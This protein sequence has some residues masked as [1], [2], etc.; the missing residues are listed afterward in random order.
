MNSNNKLEAVNKKLAELSDYIKDNFSNLGAMSLLR[1][2][3][4]NLVSLKE[5]V[6]FS[7]S[8]V[9]TTEPLMISEDV[10]VTG[11][12]RKYKDGQC[13]YTLILSGPKGR[14]S[15]TSVEREY[16]SIVNKDLSALAQNIIPVY[17]FKQLTSNSFIKTLS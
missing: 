15:Y 4:E 1:M 2:L 7:T 3:D 5:E 6:N 12:L 10:S 16:L 9:T 17:G 13:E 8:E 14:Q 11:E